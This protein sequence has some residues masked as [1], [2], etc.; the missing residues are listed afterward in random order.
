MQC[1]YQ[2][3]DDSFWCN[4]TNTECTSY[5]AGETLAICTDLDTGDDQY[6]AI[7]ASGVI[8]TSAIPEPGTCGLTLIAWF[9][10]IR[11]RIFPP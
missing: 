10:L 1:P 5:P 9:G 7:D 6:S 4:E 3:S 8:G 2:G 11:K